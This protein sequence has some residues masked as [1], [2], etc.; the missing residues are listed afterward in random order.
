MRLP[1]RKLP[2]PISYEAVCEVALSEGCRLAAYRCPA[3]V[4]TIGWGHTDGVKEG[5]IITQA[6]ADQMLC[7]DLQDFTFA[8]QTLLELRA[9]PNQ[10]GA[11]VSLAYNIGQAG[12]SRSTVLRQHNRGNYQAAARAFGLWNKAGGRVLSGLTSRRAREAALYLTPEFRSDTE[13]M[14]QRVDPESNLRQSPI[15]QSG[16]LSI[17]SGMTAAAASAIEP[18]TTI[19]DNLRI[20]PL[21]IVGVIAIVV[22]VVVFIQRKKQR[23]GGWA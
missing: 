3:N 8:V 14:P 19:A 15:A 11:M 20:D 23:D 13:E 21:L 17:A 18:V 16:V 9:N 2:W 6:E 4:W 10:L 22:G 12:F 7:D 5:D 1:D